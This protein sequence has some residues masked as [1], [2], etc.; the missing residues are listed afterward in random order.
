[1][2]N[3]LIYYVGNFNIHYIYIEML[4]FSNIFEISKILYFQNENLKMNQLFDKHVL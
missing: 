1:M 4:R 3:N 2:E